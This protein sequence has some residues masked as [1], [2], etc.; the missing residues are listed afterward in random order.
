MVIESVGKEDGK[1]YFQDIISVEVEGFILS[2]EDA[3]ELFIAQYPMYMIVGA[4][5]F[6]GITLDFAKHLPIYS[7]SLESDFGT[8]AEFSKFNAL[9][10]EIEF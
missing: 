2:F 6:E 9:T 3:R 5:E 1:V 4:E 7:M 8:A 10:G